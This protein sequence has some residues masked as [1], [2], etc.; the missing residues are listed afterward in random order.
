[1]QRILIEIKGGMV[2]GVYADNPDLQVIVVDWDDLAA[3]ADVGQMRK[4]C[5]SPAD[6]TVAM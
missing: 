2:Q 3:G 6:L 5:W 4:K 1:M